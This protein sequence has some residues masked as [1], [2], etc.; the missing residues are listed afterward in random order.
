MGNHNQ[1][2]HRAVAHNAVE[3]CVLCGDKLGGRRYI[4]RPLDYTGFRC[5]GCYTKEVTPA[6]VQRLLKSGYSPAKTKQTY[7]NNRLRNL[8][9][10]WD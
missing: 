1:G 3:Y 8:R 6:R 7:I 9:I 5:W 2:H 4:A 10:V